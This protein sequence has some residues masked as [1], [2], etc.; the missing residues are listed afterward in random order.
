MKTALYSTTALAAA[1]LLTLGAGD[2]FAGSHSGMKKAQ[3]LKV[4]VG[5]FFVSAIGFADNEG[6][7]ETATGVDYSSFNMYNDSEI[8]FRG[9]TRL[10]NGIRVDVRIE[11]EADQRS[12]NSSGDAPASSNAIDESYIRFTGG[13]GDL[14][15]GSTKHANFVLKHT[16]PQ[17][18][19]FPVGNPRI[20]DFIVRPAGF[21]TG[22][23]VVDTHIGASDAMKIVYFSPRFE[24]FGLGVSYRPDNQNS[25]VIADNSSN[26]DHGAFDATLTF[27]RKLGDVQVLADVGYARFFGRGKGGAASADETQIMGG[28]TLGFAGWAIGGRY[29]NSDDSGTGEAASTDQDGYTVGVRYRSGPWGVSLVYGHNEETG[30]VGTTANTREDDEVTQIQLGARYN[31]GPGI[32]LR[33]SV[34]HMDYDDE[35]TAATRENEG[36]AAI[37]GIR[38]GF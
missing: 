17:E 19:L 10:D 16:T 7:F 28:L 29:K 9:N 20:R 15:L 4:G 26:S 21:T 11:L 30:A 25:D 37:A 14:R 13:F 3:K 27:E 6:A 24:G 32:S 18:G 22:P 12:G 36:W 38:V 33:G 5:G 8:I 23:A 35:A 1:S 34:T 2:A 31:I